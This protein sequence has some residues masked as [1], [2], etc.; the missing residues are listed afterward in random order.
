[1]KISFDIDCSPEEARRF[2]GLPDVTPLQKNLMAEMEK[3]LLATVAGMD[4]ETMMRHWM[5]DSLPAGLQEGLKGMENLG[6]MFWGAA[7]AAASHKDQPAA[8]KT[9]PADKSTRT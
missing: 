7:A 8:G 6:R 9:G 5:P 1:M 2:F 4:A 3:R